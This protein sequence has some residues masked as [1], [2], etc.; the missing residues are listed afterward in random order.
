TL[1]GGL[2]FKIAG[3]DCGKLPVILNSSQ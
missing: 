3:Y 1:L 2:L